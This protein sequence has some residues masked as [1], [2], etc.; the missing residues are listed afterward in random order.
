[1]VEVT[2]GVLAEPCSLML[3]DFFRRRREQKKL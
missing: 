1:M 2:E 3:S